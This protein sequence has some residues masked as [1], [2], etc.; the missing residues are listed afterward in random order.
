MST[1]QKYNVL[2][3]CDKKE[4]LWKKDSFRQTTFNTGVCYSQLWGASCVTTCLQYMCSM[5]NRV[6]VSAGA[7]KF[8]LPHGIL[9]VNW[10][11]EKVHRKSPISHD[12]HVLF[13]H[14][15]TSPLMEALD[16]PTASP[17]ASVPPSSQHSPPSL[18]PSLPPAR[19]C[20][21]KPPPPVLKS[22][23]LPSGPS[24]PPSTPPALPPP[25][26]PISMSPLSLSSNPTQGSLP[27]P[28]SPTLVTPSP[29]LTL[30]PIALSD[31]TPPLSP[32]ISPSLLVTS[33]SPTPSLLSP[34]DRLL[35]STSVW[36]PKG[37]SQDQTMIIME[38]AT[39]GV[40]NTQIHVGF[41]L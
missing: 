1:C 22:S 25:L 18:P 27:P 15:H 30:Q 3:F 29:S 4:P 12:W 28:L 20:R 41:C 6:G 36:Q 35:G 40:S 33:S 8:L 17:V 37:L 21:P 16:P 10:S 38:R 7:E 24:L 34:I 5:S 26:P 31:L 39:A 23:Q 32:T 2:L 13:L 19:P 11:I 9:G 14:S